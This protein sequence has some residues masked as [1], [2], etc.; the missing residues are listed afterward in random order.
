[1]QIR[2]KPLPERRTPETPKKSDGG[3]SGPP[4]TWIEYLTDVYHTALRTGLR[5]AEALLFTPAELYWR[6][7]GHFFDAGERE[8]EAWERDAYFTACLMNATGNYKRPV[9]AGDLIR[10]P[11]R[12]AVKTRV[13]AET[14]RQQ[15]LE[16]ARLHKKKFW[17]L[18]K[19]KSPE[20]VRFLGE[21][22][23]G[24]GEKQDV[25]PAAPDDRAAKLIAFIDG[26]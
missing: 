9:K 16:T 24:E 1:M 18:I 5:P 20:D 23:A 15:A 17:R 3:E 7:K 6:F 10:L 22:A 19:G 14:R 11:K 12:P 26:K 2:K 13:D 21:E 4:L 8:R 25:H